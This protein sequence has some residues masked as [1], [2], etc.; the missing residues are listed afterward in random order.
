MGRLSPLSPRPVLPI[1]HLITMSLITSSEEK[2]FNNYLTVL[3]DAYQDDPLKD[4]AVL[5][6]DVVGSTKYFKIYGDMDGREMLR[7]HQNL[8][9]SVIDEYKGKL[10]KAIGDSV[11]ASFAGPS[12]A[13]R[14]AIKMQRIFSAYNDNAAGEHRIHIR[15]GVH[16]GKVIVEEKDIYGDVVNVASKLTNL[17]NGDEIYISK[18]IYER[19]QD[20]PGIHFELVNLWNA[21]DAPS[22]LT[23]YKAV[24][25]NAIIAEPVL[26]TFIHVHPLPDIGETDFSRIWENF[27]GNLDAEDAIAKGY[28][29]EYILPDRSLSLVANDSIYAISTAESILAHLGSI[30]E[31]DAPSPVPVQVIIYKLLHTEGNMPALTDIEVKWDGIS[32]GGIYVSPEVRLD[33]KDEGDIFVE[34]STAEETQE[35]LYRIYRK[36][37]SQETTEEQQVPVQAF[38]YQMTL[39]DGTYASCY[40]CG[41]RRH[42]PS[43]C[44]SKNI[45]GKTSAISQLGYLSLSTINDLFLRYATASLASSDNGSLYDAATEQAYLAFYEL[46]RIFQLPFFRIIWN[47]PA[48][49][50]ERVKQS[51]G[52]SEGGIVWLI[53]D[54]LRVSDH[55]R[56]QSLL[57]QA[58]DTF[59]D[60]Y[61]VYCLLGYLNIEQ[62]DLSPAK[63]HFK[64]AYTYA[65][66][67]P[68]RIFVLFQLAR[69]YSLLNNPQKAHEKIN[70]ILVIDHGCTEA[71]YQDIIWKLQQKKEKAAIQQLAGLVRENRDYYTIALIDP[72]MEPYKA[73]VVPKLGAMFN[74]AKD[75]AQS[76]F[77]DACTILKNTKELLSQMKLAETESLHAKVEELMK[78]DS[79]F[80]YLDAVRY[81]DSIV[82][83]CENSLKEQKKD[84]SGIIDQ[85]LQRL[86]RALNFVKRYRYRQFVDSHYKHLMLLKVRMDDIKGA[87]KC[88]VLW[89][90]DACHALCKE[91]AGELDSIESRLKRLEIIQQVVHTFFNFLKYCSALLSIVFF[92]GIFIF[93]FFVDPLNALLSKFEITSISSTWSFQKTF[94]VLG[95][96]ASFITSFLISVKD[97]FKD[98]QDIP[99]L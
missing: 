85:L 51:A 39:M 64:K 89:Q 62:N 50:W 32:P 49:R 37:I 43:D 52:Q 90:F 41:N 11:M 87:E 80:G 63:E 10:I 24:W 57:E 86:E 55:A 93:P 65:K 36:N 68:Q 95:G 26:K 34:P 91:T 53:Q 61:K 28:E 59:P 16:F 27:I 79:Y 18:E 29:E 17:A 81:S 47:N 42:Y 45:P 38:L 58:L 56:A 5:F 6:T 83:A 2:P 33:I 84:L 44:P 25:E 94:L 22:G 82:T 40:Y 77:E 14:A 60:D 31:K 54:S 20:I 96:I 12:E 1:T 69:L 97:I 4:I 78:S 21:K 8:A 73:I 46:K 67:K 23:M 76:R 88:S 15:I 13:L 72:E 71:I 30:T 9:S 48:N 99:T 98:D 19:A 3:L 35:T 92:T 75:A 7:Q 70:N 74:K 66:T